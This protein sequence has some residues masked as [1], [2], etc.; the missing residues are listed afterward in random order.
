MDAPRTRSAP[1]QYPPL[2]PRGCVSSISAAR[3]S[4]D[5]ALSVPRDCILPGDHS[6]RGCGGGEGECVPFPPARDWGPKVRAFI[7][8]SST[9]RV[10]FERPAMVDGSIAELPSLAL[11]KGICLRLFCR[12]RSR[13]GNVI[14][15]WSRLIT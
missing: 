4:G 7:A 11:A 6:S 12:P 10:S 8:C 13:Q 14:F 9:A 5:A 3:R 2:L 15:L 1:G